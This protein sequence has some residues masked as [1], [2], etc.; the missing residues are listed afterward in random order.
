MSKTMPP[1]QVAIDIETVELTEEPTTIVIE[2]IREYDR[3]TA[4]LTSFDDSPGSDWN[5]LANQVFGH[6]Q[7]A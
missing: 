7:K 4:I 6:E 3:E 2:A 5:L 1:G